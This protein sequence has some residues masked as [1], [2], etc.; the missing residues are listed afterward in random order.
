V[1]SCE[2]ALARKGKGK[3][4]VKV[5]CMTVKMETVLISG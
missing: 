2:P 3:G 5:E 1:T 4:A